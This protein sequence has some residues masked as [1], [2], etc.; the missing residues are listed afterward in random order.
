MRVTFVIP[1]PAGGGTRSVTTL[2]NGL[3]ERGHTVR[4]IHPRPRRGLKGA[5]RYFYVGLRFGHRQDWLREFRGEVVEY[6]ELSASVAGEN[7]VVVGVGVDCMLAVSAL[8]DACGIKVHN[9]HGMEPWIIRRM[10]R[11]WALPVPRIICASYLETEMR[12]LGSRDPI[13][14]VPN[15]V[16]A[17]QYYPD[18]Q[19]G[20]RDGVGTV[21][22]KGVAKDPD[23]VRAALWRIH[24][25]DPDLPL[26]VFG[27]S[28]PKSVP[29][30]VRHARFPTIAQ[31]RALYSRS[32]VWFCGS[33]N[34]GFSMPLLEAMAC[35]CA[36]VS[37]DCGG[38]SDF[39]DHGKSGFIV[40][41]EHPDAIADRVA[42]ILDDPARLAAM[43]EAATRTA[44][45]YSWSEASGK[46]EAALEK[47][48][49][50]HGAGVTN[51]NL[52]RVA[53]DS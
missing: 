9:C 43:A 53:R 18:P 12:H 29:P 41:V 2:A 37:T 31:A 16:D 27:T 19:A 52:E 7:D 6:T 23:T 8:P 25:R 34:E 14:L 22:H 13:V 28:K 49:A 33:R 24:D 40:P 46:L 42:A 48:L 30:S 32:L 51:G 39:V 5:L 1:G 15:G 3:I 47:I 26:Y 35:G 45:D 44:R 11:V 20:P 4:I 10:R 17:S 21:F 36:A 50:R 38:P